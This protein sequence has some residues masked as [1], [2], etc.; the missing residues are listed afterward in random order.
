VDIRLP[1][2]RASAAAVVGLRNRV[3]QGVPFDLAIMSLDSADKGQQR[4]SNRW[5][6]ALNAFEITCDGRL[7]A[8]RK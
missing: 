7:S 6:A 3:D 8:G 1:N 5:Q 2:R 4:W